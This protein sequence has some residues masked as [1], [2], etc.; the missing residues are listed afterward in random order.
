M[1]ANKKR[2]TLNVGSNTLDLKNKYHQHFIFT[3]EFWMKYCP[4]KI[5][6]SVCE[7]GSPEVCPQ[8]TVVTYIINDSRW[9]TSGNVFVRPA[10][11][12]VFFWWRTSSPS[13]EKNHT[14]PVSND[15]REVSGKWDQCLPLLQLRIWVPLTDYL[16][17]LVSG[18]LSYKIKITTFPYFTEMFWSLE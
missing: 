4:V 10:L 3:L 6:T 9:D 17:S 7:P 18:F 13:G 15:C 12:R 16:P 5:S 2:K 11:H 14:L 1:E 8:W